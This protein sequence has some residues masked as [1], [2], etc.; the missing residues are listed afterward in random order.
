MT[1]IINKV[2]TFDARV[3][4]LDEKSKHFSYLRKEECHY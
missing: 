4:T 1:P 3:L 2:G